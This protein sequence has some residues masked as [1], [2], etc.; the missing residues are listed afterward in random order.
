MKLE[1]KQWKKTLEKRMKEVG[2]V[3]D[4]IREDISEMEDLRDCCERA[5]EDIQRAID[6]LSEL[7]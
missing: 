1:T 5:Y 3:R 2:S 7:A 4:Q 6:A